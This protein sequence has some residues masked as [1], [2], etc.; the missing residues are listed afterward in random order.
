MQLVGLHGR[1][2]MMGLNHSSNGWEKKDCEGK[3]G[4]TGEPQNHPRA[5][6]PGS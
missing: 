3:R 1:S 4:S 5:N 2:A 6:S